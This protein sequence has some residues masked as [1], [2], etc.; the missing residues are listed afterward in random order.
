M[1]ISDELTDSE[2]VGVRVTAG[3]A[4]VGHVEEGQV[5]LGQADLRDL[6]PLLGGRVDTSRVVGAGMEKESRAGRRLLEVLNHALEVKANGVL[7]VVTVVL[8]LEA[9]VLEDGLVVG[10]RRGRDADL[11]LARV[12]AVEELSTNA[13]GTGAGDGL[14]DGDAVEHWGVVAVGELGGGGR[15]LGDTSDAGVLLVHLVVDDAPLSLAD[16]GEDVGLA[17]VI[18]VRANT[19][20]C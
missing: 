6:L 16:G 12:P 18:T 5:T 20:G 17:G 9:R 4:L 10:P 2:G 19:W 13:Q 3:E 15:E 8:D 7:V 14:G 1:A 11:L